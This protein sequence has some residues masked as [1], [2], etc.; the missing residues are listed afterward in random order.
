MTRVTDYQWTVEFYVEADGTTPVS[1]WL[2]EELTAAERR[3]VTA[4]LRE[5]VAAMGHDVCKTEFGK[6]LG[7]GII[8]LRLRQ[9]EDQLMRRLG[10]GGEPPVH[11]E[12]EGT[13]I[14]LRV[15]FHPHGEKRALVLHGYSKGDN[16]SKRHQQ[17]QIDL[18]EKRLARWKVRQAE[19][20]KAA[21]RHR[22]P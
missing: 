5:L 3:T 9:T 21:K 6:N 20:L 11:P 12:D 13:E 14:F 22:K 16:S 10:R 18:A 2:L 17:K 4:A 1:D 15:F 7:G 19:A 8:E